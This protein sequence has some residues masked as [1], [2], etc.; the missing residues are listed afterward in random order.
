MKFLIVA[1]IL[2][3]VTYAGYHYIPVAYNAYLYKDLM[4]TKVDAAAALGRPP[5]WVTD[6]LTKS[7]PEYEVP[8]EAVITPTVENDR[9][10]VRVQFSKVIEFPGYAYVYEFDHT[11]QSTE[12]LGKKF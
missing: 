7:G 12:F 9:V 8:R 4:Q 10:K 6:Q 3:A 5:L 1:L 11:A 2:G